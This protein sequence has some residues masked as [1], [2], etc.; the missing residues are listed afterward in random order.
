[1]LATPP[2]EQVYE[3]GGKLEVREMTSLPAEHKRIPNGF[4]NEYPGGRVAD[5]FE[6]SKRW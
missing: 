6:R 5:E 4:D 3:W 2:R 1:M